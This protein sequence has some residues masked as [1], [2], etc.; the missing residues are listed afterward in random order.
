MDEKLKQL[1]LE[2]YELTDEHKQQLDENGFTVFEDVISGDWLDALR[3]SFEQICDREGAEAGKEVAQMEGARRLADLVNKGEVYDQLYLQPFLL[4]TVGYVMQQ[5]FKLHSVNGHDPLP[6]SGQQALHADWPG[7]RTAAH[8]VNSMWML[9][10]FTEENGATRIVPASHRDLRKVAE[11]HPDRKAPIP[12]E[13]R[14]VGKAGSVGIF[15]GNAWHS[16]STNLNGKLRR[17]VHCAFI[18]RQHP[19]QTDQREYL[20]KETAARLSPLAQ[21]ILDVEES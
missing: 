8:V 11:I 3:Q 19:Q 2:P 18:A 9:D 5:P 17:T 10:D 20:T 13:I 15:N 21:Y 6:G 1:G 12:C 7:D 14:L 16:S 4:A